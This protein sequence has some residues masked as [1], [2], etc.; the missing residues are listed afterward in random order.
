MKL[1]SWLLTGFIIVLLMFSSISFAKVDEWIKKAD[2]STARGYLSTSEV[3]GKIY[4]IGG[5]N[6]VNGGVCTT[7]QAVEAYDPALDKWTV[8]TNMPTSRCYM[9]AC[10]V[11]GKIYAIGGMTSVAASCSNVEEYDPTSNRWTKKNGM[12]IARFCL[13]GAVV[14]GRIYA[15]GGATDMV[16]Q[17][18]NGVEICTLAV[19]EYDPVSDKWIEKADMP[20]ARFGFAAAEVNNKIYAIGGISSNMWLSTVGEYDTGFAGESVE[21]QGKLATNW[22]EIKKQ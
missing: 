13:A 19:E 8:M 1:K 14:K 11:N 5:M 10:T 15:I 22:G 21:A 4:A 9:I 6:Y 18:N 2:M 12:P 17:G 3:N 16:L 20:T 7:L